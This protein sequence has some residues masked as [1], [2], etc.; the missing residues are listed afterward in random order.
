M[1]KV[2]E[3]R[4]GEMAA[5]LGDVCHSLFGVRA[6][7]PPIDGWAS[8]CS[9]IQP[10][11]PP[12]IRSL[13]HRLSLFLDF[14]LRTLRSS[15][16]LFQ[17]SPTLRKKALIY[18]FFLRFNHHHKSDD[19]E[20]RNTVTGSLGRSHLNWEVLIFAYLINLADIAVNVVLLI[21]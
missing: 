19:V 4:T 10:L 12:H 11:L 14:S 15:C 1:R 20:K 2:L 17:L 6:A 16:P 21:K 3:S 9:S 8:G 5:V 13:H 7:P 18:F